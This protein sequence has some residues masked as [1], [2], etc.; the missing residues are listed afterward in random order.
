MGDLWMISRGLRRTDRGGNTP[1]ALRITTF[2][3]SAMPERWSSRLIQ[4]LSLVYPGYV[5]EHRLPQCRKATRY[6]HPG[7]DDVKTL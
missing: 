5:Y 6:V 2:R 4:D 7:T 3:V 1:V